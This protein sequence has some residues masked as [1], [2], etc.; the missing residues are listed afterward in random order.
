MF[1]ILWFWRNFSPAHFLM[2]GDHDYAWLSSYIIEL[3]SS[4]SSSLS[5]AYS[6][7]CQSSKEFSTTGSCFRCAV[8]Y[9]HRIRYFCPMPLSS[10]WQQTI[11]KIFSYLLK[12]QQP[13]SEVY[14]RAW[15]NIF[16]SPQRLLIW[17]GT[18]Y[19]KT[20]AKSWF[21]RENLFLVHCSSRHKQSKF[22]WQL[23]VSL[24]K[25]HYEARI[26]FTEKT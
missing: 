7:A 20:P 8:M 19:L 12:N 25:K 17:W 1:L 26:Y 3:P 2:C 4:S 24:M 16:C 6:N 15:K 10:F 5:K 9:H 23:W 22:Q 14:V 11:V 21:K 18:F 13:I